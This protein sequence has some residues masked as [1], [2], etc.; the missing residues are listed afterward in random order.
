MPKSTTSDD[1]GTTRV[2]TQ[3]IACECCGANFERPAGKAGR[4]RVYCSPDCKSLAQ[5][6]PWID[7]LVSNGSFKPTDEK[8]RQIRQHLWSIGNRVWNVNKKQS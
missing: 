7:N 5:L 1:Q 8:A 2:N 4:P 6:L 3:I